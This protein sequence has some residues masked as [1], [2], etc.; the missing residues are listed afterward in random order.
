MFSGETKKKNKLHLIRPSNNLKLQLQK[1]VYKNNLKFELGKVNEKRS[2]AIVTD[3]VLSFGIL[4]SKKNKTI[5]EKRLMA[6]EI[7]DTIR[8]LGIQD[9]NY[10]FLNPVNISISADNIIQELTKCR[11][12]R[13]RFVLESL[14]FNSN[15]KNE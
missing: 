5:G 2:F 14:S 1:D 8:V 11:K 3:R 13:Y 7:I 4:Q 10:H 15:F 12:Y 9:Q 6:L